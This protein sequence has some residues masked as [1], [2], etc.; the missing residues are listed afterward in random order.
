M[1]TFL[2]AVDRQV[3]RDALKEFSSQGLDIRLGVQLETVSPQGEQVTL[4]YLDGAGESREL[5]ANRVVVA[6][7]RRPFTDDLGLEAIGI[8]VDDQGRIPVDDHCH[9][10]V[11]GIYAIG[12]VVRGPM[13]A[14]KGSE[15][16]VAVAE[17]LAGRVGHVDYGIIPW[18]IYTDP[19][20]AW[21]GETE[22]GLEAA[23]RDYRSGVFPFRA[24]GRAHGAGD[25]KGF[26]KV[27]GDAAT[28]RILG[29]HII[30]HHAS[31][32]IAEA[33]TAMAFAASTEDLGR[34]VHAHPTLSE[35]LH[36]AALAVDQR[37]LHV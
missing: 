27:L 6:V 35:S 33:V 13:L 12:D 17:T 26:V 5:V 11:D 34:I 32:L 19:E 10:G 14:H 24:S 22:Q 25:P 3:A 7:G 18:V 20:V 29:V 8:Q 31:E 37:A 1:D 30:G 4:G 21:V 2:P 9:A 36:E 15:E 23:G 28:D 16:G